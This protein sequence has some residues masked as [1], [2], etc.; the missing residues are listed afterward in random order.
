MFVIYSYNTHNVSEFHSNNKYLALLIKS[1]YFR[2]LLPMHCKSFKTIL[3]IS[4][5]VIYSYN[6]HNVSEFRNNNQY[7]A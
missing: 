7:H 2:S 6:T 1:L 3:K 4:I 5:F